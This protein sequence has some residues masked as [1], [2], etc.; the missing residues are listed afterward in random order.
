MASELNAK[1][2]L[3]TGASGF[4][5]SHLT[6]RLVS[7]GAEVGVVTRYNSIIDNVRIADIW[8][9][10]TVIEADLRNLD[11]LGRISEF[12]PDIVYHFAAY[13]HVGDSFSQVSEVMD[14]NA[15]GTAN[16]ITAY[17]DFE[18]FVYI[19]TSEVYG[20]QDS[21]PFHEGMTPRPVSPYA[22]G[23][24]SGE[25]YCRMLMEERQFPFVLLRPFNA[26]GPYQSVRAIIPEVILNCLAGNPIKSTA[27]TQTREFNFVSNLVEA[28]I[29]AGERE[30]AV[31]ELINVGCGEEIAIRDLIALIHQETGSASE[32]RIGELPDRPTEIWRMAA[33]NSRANELLG[34]SPKLSFRDG[35]RK[36]IDWYRQ[37]Q[38]IYNDVD[39]PLISLARSASE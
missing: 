38:S 28:F 23:K 30:A 20:S 29:A 17:D 34:W 33:D 37:F 5:A 36:S 3:I 27:G 8:N 24:Y 39:S 13:N 9:D 16:L 19:S 7:E 18:R 10:V 15:K 6:R 35:I 31:G 25:L 12:H 26:F 1:R 22:V 11:A 2:V 32:L 14:V 21:V 4:I